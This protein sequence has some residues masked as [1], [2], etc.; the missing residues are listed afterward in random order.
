MT[1]QASPNRFLRTLMT[2]FLSLTAAVTLLGGIGTTCVAFKAENFGPKMATLVPVK[3]IFQILVFVSI[4][5]AIYGIY[6]IVMLGKGRQKSYNMTLAF[7]LVGLISSGIQYY[8][9]ATLRGSTAPNNVRLY[10]T[11]LTLV[12][13]L[14]TRLPSVREKFNYESSNQGG[15]PA[16]LRSAGGAALVL[17]GLTTLTTPLWVQSSHVIAG[18]NTANVLLIPLLVAG[19]L[20]ITAGIALLRNHKV[21]GILRHSAAA[22]CVPASSSTS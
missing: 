12:L 20:Q 22:E 21:E 7:L 3:P 19:A 18:V 5:A 15:G 8:Y 1:Q 4:A 6:S 9:S 13:F 10:L 17:C 2:V 16:G 11:A 14:L